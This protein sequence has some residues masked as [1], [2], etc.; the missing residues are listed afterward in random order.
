[1]KQNLHALYCRAEPVYFEFP[2]FK[3]HSRRDYWLAIIQ[4]VLQV[5]RFIRKF[6]LEE[7]QQREALSKA[8]LGIFRYR[9]VKEAFHITPYHFKM[10]LAFN[11][12]EKLPKG[13]M[14]LEA[15]YNHLELLHTGYQCPFA[16]DSS[17][18]KKLQALPLPSSSYTLFKM[19]LLKRKYKMNERDFLVAVVCIGATSPLEMAVKE[20]FCHSEIAEAACATVDQVK[21]EGIDRNIA[22]ML[23]CNHKVLSFL[24]QFLH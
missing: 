7:I 24:F 14:I 6:N 11:L 18:D 8:A 22:V 19:G 5:H 2:E 4:E 13:D 3:G 16:S 1:M 20:S 23:V 10:T 9:A 21:V 12:A 15:L 17:S